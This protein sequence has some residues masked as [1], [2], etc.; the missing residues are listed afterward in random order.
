MSRSKPKSRPPGEGVCRVCHCHVGAGK[1]VWDHCHECGVELGFRGWICGDCNISLTR[2]LIRNWEAATDYLSNHQCA[3][4]LFDM[5]WSSRPKTVK[6]TQT[7]RCYFG[8]GENDPRYIMVSVDKSFITVEQLAGVLGVV[9]G[10]AR[11][12]VRKRAGDG[13]RNS[14]ILIPLPKAFEIIRKNWK[15]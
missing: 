8:N 4:S 2:N 5:P 3:P 13:R 11:D 12:K 1:L 10:T 7:Q 15:L 6:K 14:L 9:A